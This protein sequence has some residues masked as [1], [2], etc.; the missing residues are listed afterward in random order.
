MIHTLMLI[1]TI[2]TVVFTQ[3]PYYRVTVL[4]RATI[5]AFSTQTS[6]VMFRTGRWTVGSAVARFTFFKKYNTKY[7]CH[8]NAISP[9]V[10]LQ[11]NKFFYIWALEDL[12]WFMNKEIC[13]D[14]AIKYTYLRMYLPFEYNLC[15]NA[16]WK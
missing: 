15:S 8:Q 2:N 14:N 16:Y 13:R 4:L 12:D 10:I 6:I 3:T 5:T 9:K 7:Q 1:C 11:S